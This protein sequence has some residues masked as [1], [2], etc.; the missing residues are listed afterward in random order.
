VD[1]PRDLLADALAEHAMNDARLARTHD[2]EVGVALLRERD[3]R[4]RRFADGRDELGRADRSEAYEHSE[5]ELTAAG[6]G[7]AARRS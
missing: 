6:C 7:R 4:P 2:D 5:E 1:P 3:D